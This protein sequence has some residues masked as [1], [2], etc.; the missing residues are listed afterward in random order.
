[1]AEKKKGK[2]LAIKRHAMKKDLIYFALPALIVFFFELRL[3]VQDGFDGFWGTLWNLIKRPATLLTFNT[4]S[5]LGMALTL[6]GFVFLLMGQI[7]LGTNHS[8]SV[9][10]RQDHELI[11]HGIYRIT[12]NPMYFGLLLVVIGLPVY[13]TSLRGFLCS[14]FLIPLVLIRIKLEEELLGEEFQSDY[15]DYKETTKRLIPFVY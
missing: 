11:T 12:R 14:L 3:C 1:M 4:V 2:R 7:T 6:V 5:V 13:S 8:S 15:K 9:V 10:I